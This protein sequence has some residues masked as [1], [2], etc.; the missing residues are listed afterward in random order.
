MR[1]AAPAALAR[2]EPGWRMPLVA[3]AASRALVIALG[4]AASLA[5][6][7]PERGVDPAVPHALSLLGGWDTTWYLDVARHGYAH[8]TGQVG[9]VFTNLAFFPLLPA[10]MA[11][12]LAIG[13][14]PFIAALV[15]S[16]L[17][18][19][20]A[21]QGFHV[22]SA[23]RF[24]DEAAA[25]ATW[26][27]ALLPTAAYA[28]LAYTEGIVLACAL[29]AALAGTRGRPGLAGLAAAAATLA[30]P[31]GILV[32]LLAGLLA[33]RG[34][35]AGRARRVALAVGPSLVALAA[36]LTWMA[37]ARGSA[38]LPFEAQHAWDR[39]QVGIGL[40]TAAPSEIAA[41]W[42]HLVSGTGG[43]AWHATI[44]DL[45]FLVLYLWLLARLWRSEGGL[46]SPWVAYSAAAIALPLSSGT[47]TSMA[48]F[49]LLAFPLMW[50]LG[51]WLG[52][53]R[54]RAARWAGAAVVVIAL[55]VAQLT[56]RSP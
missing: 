32:A 47:I 17:A 6:G 1:T 40:V 54:G 21:L 5:F 55:L 36:F 50:A 28:S 29:G 45:A 16:N 26:A 38:L 14:N 48:R 24:G 7:V 15:V 2:A 46:R 9:E 43:A 27:L 8:D 25:R 31:T 11:A 22:L 23:E 30:R 4:I 35:A 44:R 56:M 10:V 39:G 34:P 13:L 18:F 52:A 3:W 20:A 53:E 33:L 51:D 41:G 49:G 19:L 12:A 37:V 42:H